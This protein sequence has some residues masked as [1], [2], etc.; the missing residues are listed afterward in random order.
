MYFGCEVSLRVFG[1]YVKSNV[2]LPPAVPVMIEDLH[3]KCLGPP[4][5]LVS[6]PPHTDD[7]QGGPADV[8]THGALW[9][10]LIVVG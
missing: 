7:A 8:H 4:G 9:Q 2:L 5:H 3:I 10:V 6:Y 1:K